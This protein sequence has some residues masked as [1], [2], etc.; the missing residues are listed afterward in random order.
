MGGSDQ[1]GNITA[2]M[3]LI[4][5]LRGGRAHGIVAPLVTTSAGTKLGKSEAGAVWPDPAMPPPFRFY[6]FWLTIDA[7]A[8]SRYLRSSP[9]SSRRELAPPAPPPPDS[10]NRAE[11]H[12]PSPR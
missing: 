10:P 7:G 6:Q 12:G 8:A 1:W 4:R 5:K 9:S 2:G 3:D 11:P